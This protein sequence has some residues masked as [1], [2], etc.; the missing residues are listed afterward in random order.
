MSGTPKA[1][2][3]IACTCFVLCGKEGFEVARQCLFAGECDVLALGGGPVLIG[4]EGHGG[5]L[6][7]ARGRQRVAGQV[8]RGRPCPES[9]NAIVPRSIIFAVVGQEN[10]P[11]LVPAMHPRWCLRRG[12]GAGLAADRPASGTT[13]ARSK[14]ASI[15]ATGLTF[16]TSVDAFARNFG[17]D[18]LEGEAV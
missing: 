5:V 6:S 16:R 2:E 11:H 13:G 17:T 14:S 15:G 1:S 3:H 9:R 18:V 12:P 8:D 10:S 4:S 7:S